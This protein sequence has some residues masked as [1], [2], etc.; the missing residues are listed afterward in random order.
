MVLAVVVVV[1]GENLFNESSRQKKQRER[2]REREE[3]EEGWEEQ[4]IKV[5]VQGMRCPGPMKAV[6]V[7]CLLDKC[8]GLVLPKLD[9]SS[10]FIFVDIYIL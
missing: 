10:L 5:S 1:P 6:P 9:F 3:E 2:E 8:L 7:F 4:I